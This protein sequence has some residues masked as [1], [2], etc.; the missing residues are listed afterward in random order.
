M[1]KSFPSFD[2]DLKPFLNNQSG[3]AISHLTWSNNIDSVTP[4][5]TGY[6]RKD[7]VYTVNNIT[8]NPNIEAFQHKVKRTTACNGA[9]GC[10]GS[11]KGAGYKF[12]R[13]L[14]NPTYSR[15]VSEEG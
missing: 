3:E 14:F 1:L 5:Q 10:M 4:Y 15:E 12:N 7:W 8:N 13:K 2:Q 6:G 9:D 11:K